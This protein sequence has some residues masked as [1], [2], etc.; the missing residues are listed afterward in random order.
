MGLTESGIGNSER[1][2]LTYVHRSS[3]D[4]FKL[5][6]YFVEASPLIFSQFAIRQPAALMSRSELRR[7]RKPEVIYGSSDEGLLD[8]IVAACQHLRDHNNQR[9][10]IIVFDPD[11][12]K[13]L[14]NKVPQRM[15]AVHYVKERGELRAAVP[16][17]GA[18]IMAPEACGGLEFDSVV[19]AGVDEGR[20]PPPMG[21]LGRQ[22]Y[23]AIEEEAFTELYTAITRAKYRLIVACDSRRG[24]S[25]LV[26]P[27]LAAGLLEEVQK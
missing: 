21:N 17:A 2:N 10:G 8:E 18:Y 22:G 5:A 12:L 20:M 19:M 3:P 16:L 25:S 13:F 11:L 1:R 26:R 15:G 14:S 24:L 4:I 7:C 27:A 9:I 6:S 23:L